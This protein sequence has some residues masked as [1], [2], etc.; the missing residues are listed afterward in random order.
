MA[1]ELEREVERLKAEARYSLA[2]AEQSFLDMNE[3]AMMFADERNKSR[4]EVERLKAENEALRA[5]LARVSAEL[6]LPPGIGPAPGEL[7]RLL[8]LAGR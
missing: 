4:T 3:A 5:D 6:G 1:G 2:D 8:R 7:A